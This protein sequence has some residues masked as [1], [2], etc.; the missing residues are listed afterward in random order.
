MSTCLGLFYVS[1]LGITF[2]EC[3]YLPFLC[4]YFISCFFF[5]LAHSPVQCEEFLNRSIWPIDW[6]LTG[7]VTARQSEPG[8]KLMKEYYILHSSPRTGTPL[9]NVV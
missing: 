8:S 9:S 7:I 5:F 2:I 4:R 6:I 1:R 3:L